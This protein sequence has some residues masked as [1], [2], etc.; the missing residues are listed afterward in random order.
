[1]MQSSPPAAPEF[2]S[3]VALL[4]VLADPAAAKERLAEIMTAHERLD[5]RERAVVEREQAVVD[6][7][8][9]A[10]TAKLQAREDAVYKH[11]RKTLSGARAEPK[12][13][14]PEYENKL[15]ALRAV[16]GGVIVGILQ[17]IRTKLSA[18]PDITDVVVLE[19]ELRGLQKRIEKNREAQQRI[20]AS[21][22]EAVVMSIDAA[23]TERRKLSNLDSEHSSLMKTADAMQREL[24]AARAREAAAA[25]E[26]RW[27]EAERL[28]DLTL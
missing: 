8:V 19:R 10:A 12:H 15:N 11:E 22:P 7:A 17:Q 28:R 27:R 26:A 14:A 3:T 24:D 16:D 23:A 21:I 4:Q 18:G 5:A 6:A 13:C 20:E 9:V 2:A 1:M 25:L